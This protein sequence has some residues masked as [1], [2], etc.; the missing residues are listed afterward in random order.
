[1]GSAAVF[2]DKRDDLTGE[3]DILRSVLDVFQDRGASIRQR[4]GRNGL[5]GIQSKI[6]RKFE[7][8]THSGNAADNVGA[9]DWVAL[10]IMEASIQTR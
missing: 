7:F 9:I 5:S 8:A 3:I 6:E 4:P 1:M 2:D 10:A